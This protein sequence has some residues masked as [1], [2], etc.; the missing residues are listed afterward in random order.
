[1]IA[2]APRS[3]VFVN[4]EAWLTYHRERREI[5][6]RFPAFSE[7][8]EGMSLDEH[9]ANVAQ[10]RVAARLELRQAM[11]QMASLGFEGGYPIP[12]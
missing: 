4:L 8:P 10:L 7:A 3:F 5:D 1:M 9:W 12:V 6:R 11:R 2:N